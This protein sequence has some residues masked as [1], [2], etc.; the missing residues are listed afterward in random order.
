MSK[1]SEKTGEM[2]KFYVDINFKGPNE[3]IA[4]HDHIKGTVIYIGP[5]LA[6]SA[7]FLLSVVLKI[8]DFN[9]GTDESIVSVKEEIDK[10]TVSLQ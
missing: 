1:K 6:K 2:K 4:H 7:S 8:F 3:V 10:Q 9:K 5:G